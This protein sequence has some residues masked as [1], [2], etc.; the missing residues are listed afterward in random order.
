M[1][2]PGQLAASHRRVEMVPR[3]ACIAGGG[4]PLRDP[5]PPPPPRC[6][7]DR[8]PCDGLARARAGRAPA[9]P[10]APYPPQTPLYP[11]CSPPLERAS[12]SAG[13]HDWTASFAGAPWDF[14]RNIVVAILGTNESVELCVTL[15]LRRAMTKRA[16]DLC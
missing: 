2:H 9:P 7:S 5:P 16:S 6:P 12:P 14:E 13:D 15:G 11:W 1:P 8:L 4:A 10:P 3:R